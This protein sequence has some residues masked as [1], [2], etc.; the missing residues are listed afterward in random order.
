MSTVAGTDPILS[1]RGLTRLLT[2]RGAQLAVV[3]LIV[4]LGLDC[5]LVLTRALNPV[6]TQASSGV[7][8]ALI[9]RHSVNPQVTMATIIN[10]HL[11]G[12]AA[13]ATGPN[14]PPTNMALILA[15]VIAEKN[16]ADGRAIIGPNAAAAKLYAVGAMI[17]G[18]A[19]LHAVYADRVLLEHNGALETLML[20]RTLLPGMAD[21]APAAPPTRTSVQGNP[22]VLA[23][24][25]QVQPVF[26]QGKLAGYRIFPGPKNGA[27]AFRQ[28]GLIA[29][30]LIVAVNGTGLDD[31]GRALEVLQTLSSSDSATITV[32]RNG[33][34]QE[35]NLNLANLAGDE[36]TNDG[37][38]ATGQSPA[39]PGPP[40]RRL[41]P[42]LNVPN[43]FGGAGGQSVPQAGAIER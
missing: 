6:G 1:F 33:T 9:A 8:A 41:P 20:P 3:V 11:F 5:A 29:G 26:S 24:L 16:P 22:A 30:D 2:D 25:V 42:G 39:S 10:A 31:P 37:A 38:Q 40:I 28:L 18:G 12:T 14:A 17:S 36:Q 35:V 19:R 27:A 21:F 43:A 32:M 4:A 23:G 7:P 15:G 13:V 34:P